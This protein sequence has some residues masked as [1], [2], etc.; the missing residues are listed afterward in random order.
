MK[1]DLS[2]GKTACFD[3]L[4]LDKD[5]NI[6]LN[7]LTSFKLDNATILWIILN[8]YHH[9]GIAFME[10]KISEAKKYSNKKLVFKNAFEK[11]GINNENFDF[12]DDES[13]SLLIT[14]IKNKIKVKS[15]ELQELVILKAKMIEE[16]KTDF[17]K[18][19]EEEPNKYLTQLEIFEK[20]TKI[21]NN[22]NKS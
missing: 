18:K 3:I 6:I 13:T 21:I 10:T 1:I 14:A 9:Q 4:M 17:E 15:T 12:I 19:I 11:L 16:L 2:L 22:G 5:I 8:M 7:N 20:L